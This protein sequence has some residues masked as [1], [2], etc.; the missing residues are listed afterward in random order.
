MGAESVWA[1]ELP[2]FDDTA[3]CPK[4]G[5]GAVQV[6]FHRASTKGFPCG[7]PSGTRVLDG[8]L[9]RICRRCGYGWPEAPVDAEP[10]RRRGLEAVKSGQDDQP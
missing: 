2:P 1:E 8:H 5:A 9:C 10:A 6:I 3:R 7:G 4:C